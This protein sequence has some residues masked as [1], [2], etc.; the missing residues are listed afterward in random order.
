MRPH[1]EWLHTFI[2]GLPESVDVIDI[3]KR[4][5]VLGKQTTMYY[6]NFATQTSSQRQAAKDFS[7]QIKDTAVVLGNNLFVP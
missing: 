1:D 4:H 2:W 3:S 7:K 5:V 6:Q